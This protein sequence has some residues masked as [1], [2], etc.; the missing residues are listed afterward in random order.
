M[1]KGELQD[2]A[3][4][5]DTA[6]ATLVSDARTEPIQFQKTS[7]PIALPFEMRM[8]VSSPPV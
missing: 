5:G 2:L 3:I 7:L 4:D 8:P 1:F 6:E